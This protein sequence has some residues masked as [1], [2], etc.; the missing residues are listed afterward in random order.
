M[1]E[2]LPEL[3]V[4]R[5]AL[6]LGVSADIRRRR[7]RRGLAAPGAALVLLGALLVSGTATGTGWLF[8]APAPRPVAHDLHK[9]ER[10]TPPPDTRAKPA[11]DVPLGRTLAVAHGGGYTLYLLR[12][13]EHEC[14][15]VDPNGGSGCGPSLGDPGPVDLIGT[16]VHADPRV[17]E[18]PSL[19]GR[20]G[21]GSVEGRTLAPGA[22]TVDIEIPGANF[23]LTATVDP[24][25]GYFI[26]AI[27]AAAGRIILNDDDALAHRRPW[28][29]LV[30]DR[31][32][33]VIARRN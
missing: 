16:E 2:A 31:K 5:A 28:P 32:G 7:R 19:A 3:E 1:N 24:A 26:T 18:D 23:V 17:K 13:R 21:G 27:P 14:Y 22:A 11:S 29:V 8:G 9:F 15:E 10:S 33:H 12:T 25:N 6:V 30:R 20:Y 4:V